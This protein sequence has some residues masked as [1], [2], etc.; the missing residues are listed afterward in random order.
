MCKRDV[1]LQKQDYYIHI[2]MAS[3]VRS[4]NTY[5]GVRQLKSMR[6]DLEKEQSELNKEL[7]Q[8]AKHTTELQRVEERLLEAAKKGR[9]DQTKEK[10]W[11]ARWDANERKRYKLEE[12]RNRL[13]K[14]LDKTTTRQQ[15]V[16]DGKL[17]EKWQKIDQKLSRGVLSQGAL[18]EK[19]EAQK[20]TDRVD[21]VAD[22]QDEIVEELFE[23]TDK[24]KERLQQQMESAP[25]SKFDDAQALGLDEQFLTME[26][27]LQQEEKTRQE[28]QAMLQGLQNMNLK[29][30]KKKKVR[31]SAPPEEHKA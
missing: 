19:K 11:Q 29:K 16:E 27:Q 6:K 30:Q 24:A 13:D 25:S 20:L 5:V 1:Y 26:E 28:M 21:D 8:L 9:R 15:S 17:T 23:P 18:V 22:E 3:I 4:I 12:Q 7:V 14:M 10:I 2:I 31:P